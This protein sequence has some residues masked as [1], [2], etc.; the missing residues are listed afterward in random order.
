MPGILRRD[1]KIV[2]DAGKVKRTNSAGECPECCEEDPCGVCD[3]TE[4]AS[5]YTLSLAF[6][7]GGCDTPCPTDP[8]DPQPE[9][10]GIFY[11]QNAPGGTCPFAQHTDYD[12]GMMINGRHSEGV[13][14]VWNEA[15]CQWEITLFCLGV[16]TEIFWRGT[17]AENPADPTGVYTRTEGCDTTA[18]RTLS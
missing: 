7:D 14:L 16:G 15:E 6:A 12:L 10:D 13:V 11:N 3:E 9:W 18:T 17:K 5:S 2:V 1:G 8:G 4:L